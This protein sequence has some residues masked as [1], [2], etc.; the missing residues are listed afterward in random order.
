M[1]HLKKDFD[2]S[3]LPFNDDEYQEC[4]NK[5]LTFAYIEQF[6]DAPTSLSVKRAMAMCKEA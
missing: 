2:T 4:L 5:K 6:S 1:E 3:P